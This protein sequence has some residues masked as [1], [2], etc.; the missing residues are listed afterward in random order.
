MGASAAFVEAGSLDWVAPPD[1]FQPQTFVV[2]DGLW[3]GFRR[4]DKR[5]LSAVNWAGKSGRVLHCGLCIVAVS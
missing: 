1:M 5:A 4:N 3:Q 2:A